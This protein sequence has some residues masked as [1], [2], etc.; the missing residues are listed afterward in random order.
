MLFKKNNK[1]KFGQDFAIWQGVP[2]GVDF[3]VTR[4]KYDPKRVILSGLGYGDFRNYGN[5][6]LHVFGLSK[7]QI[8]KFEKELGNVVD[9]N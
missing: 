9:I 4:A 6:P 2:S 5:G 8:K 7:K 1:I 3:K